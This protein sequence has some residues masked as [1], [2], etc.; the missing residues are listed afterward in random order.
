MKS[1]TVIAAF[2]F[3]I[4][5][6][7]AQ[8]IGQQVMVKAK[9]IDVNTKQPISIDLEFQPASG[10][11]FVV[12]SKE[13]TGT[14]EQLFQANE[15]YAVTFTGDNV[16]RSESTF[17]PKSSEGYSEINQTFEVKGLAAGV[18]LEDLDIFGANSTDITAKGKE[19]LNNMKISIRFNRNTEFLFQVNA[20]NKTLADNR[21]KTLKDYTK[22]WRRLL[23][24][25]VFQSGTSGNNLLIK[26][27]K[28]EDVMK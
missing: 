7:N 17:T 27:N 3:A 2:L 8:D 16:Y 1:I 21:L 10:N 6:I 25:V 9:V 11:K 26:V 28:V 20:A 12:K 22:D 4:I 23:D 24:R 18:L 5:G 13:G 19:A 14:F 15:T